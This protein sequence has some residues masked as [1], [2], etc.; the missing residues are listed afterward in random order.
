MEAK[1]YLHT[2]VLG[3]GPAVVLLGGCPTPVE[4]LLPLARNLADAFTVFVP[5]LP[6]YGLSPALGTPYP[7]AD[8]QTLIIH[9]LHKLGVRK[10][11]LVGTSFGAWRALS[12]ACGGEVEVPAVVSLGGF[13]AID[14]A[15]KQGMAGF[16]AALRAGIDL[17][18]LLPPRF[19]SPAFL[20]AHP[21]I[22]ALTRTWLDAAPVEVIAAELEATVS[23]PDLLP[24]L[25]S[26]TTRI[27]ARVGS[28]DV[29]A[30]P[31]YAEAM[32]QAAAHGQ[33]AL[34]DGAGHALLYEDLTETTA[35]IR[36]ILAQ[37]L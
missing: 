15:A 13:A 10:A 19:L 29:A 30:P 33:L 36:E 23:L 16:A 4:Y 26:L 21:E 14:E 5:E 35:F 17:R 7:L 28:L 32:T 24:R 6:G 2:H 1:H 25:G 9:T 3:S 31:A 8:A 27:A 11:A 18:D 12:I 20:A 34:V 37:A 22:G